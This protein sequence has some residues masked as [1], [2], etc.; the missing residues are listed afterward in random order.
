[1][2]LKKIVAFIA[3]ISTIAVVVGTVCAEIYYEQPI[4]NSVINLN[5]YSVDVNGSNFSYFS[6]RKELLDFLSED[7][8]NEIPYTQKFD[9]EDFAITLQKNAM[10][11]GK[12]MNVIA[13]N[14]KEYNNMFGVKLGRFDQHIINST[15]C[16]TGYYTEYVVIDPQTDEIRRVG[17]LGR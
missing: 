12:L 15:I 17:F 4:D 1:M 6:S 11:K 14:P 7:K 2:S 10:K 3:I 5:I 13:I 9:C 8:T 16:G